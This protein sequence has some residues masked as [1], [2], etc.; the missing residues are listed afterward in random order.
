MP[1]ITVA[2]V[3]VEVTED[4]FFAEPAQWTEYMIPELAAREGIADPSEEQLRVVK[5]MR[6]QYARTGS[7]PNVRALSKTAG[8]SIKDLYRVFPGGPAKVAARIAGIP[9]PRGCI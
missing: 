9:K 3:A 7:G 1:T 6:A 2:G 4:G 5:F 8:I